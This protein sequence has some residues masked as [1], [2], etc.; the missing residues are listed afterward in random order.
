MA[1]LIKH[2]RTMLVL[3]DQKKKK[4]IVANKTTLHKQIVLKKIV[5]KKIISH[6]LYK[7]QNQKMNRKA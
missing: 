2:L 3:F 6:H 1:T 7:S 5:L 4:K